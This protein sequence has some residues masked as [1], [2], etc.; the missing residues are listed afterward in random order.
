MLRLLTPRGLRPVSPERSA[1]CLW[2]GMVLTIVLALGA[3]HLAMVLVARFT[4][5]RP[6]DGAELPAAQGSAGAAHSG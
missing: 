5:T 6:P 3:F 4:E 1:G 2:L